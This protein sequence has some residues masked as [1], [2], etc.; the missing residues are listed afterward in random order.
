MSHD[1]GY[2]TLY[3]HLSAFSAKQGDKVI[4]G[5]KIGEVGN[6][7]L[8]TGPHLHFGVFRNGKWVNPLDLLN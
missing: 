7:G 6:T 1:N 8:S 5:K 3:A 4:Q 2:Q